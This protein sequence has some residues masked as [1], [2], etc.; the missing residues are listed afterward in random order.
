MRFLESKV[1]SDLVEDWIADLV[2][3]RAKY[4]VRDRVRGSVGFKID[5][6]VRYYVWD[7][8]SNSVWNQVE[9]SK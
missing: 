1:F 4:Q 5:R 7:L 6:K 9:K 2:F 3:A 8:V